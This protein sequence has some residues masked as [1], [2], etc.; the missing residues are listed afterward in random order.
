MPFFYQLDTQT[1][2][3]LKNTKIIYPLLEASTL[4]QQWNKLC[5]V[6][7]LYIYKNGKGNIVC[8][9]IYGS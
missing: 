3:I 8:S 2:E 4:W 1:Q 7:G 9:Y 6:C 5:Q